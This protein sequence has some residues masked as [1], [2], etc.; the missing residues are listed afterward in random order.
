MLKFYKA[1]LFDLDG[2]LLDTL[3]DLG[4]S[5]N[6]VLSEKG[7]PTHPLDSYRYFAGDGSAMLIT[8][9]LPEDKRNDDM[10]RRCLDAFLKDYRRNWNVSTKPY[11]GIAEML[12]SLT[13]HPIKL[14]VL[15]N[16]PHDFAKLC[17]N[18]LLNKWRFEAILGQ[19]KNVPHK[20]DPAGA[21]EAAQILNISP[22]DFLF[23]GD[24]AVDMKTAL[25]A[26]MYPVGALWGFRPAKELLDSGAR[27]LIN[28][29]P[30]ILNLLSSK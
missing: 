4:N 20:P 13:A 26:G 1:I 6:R 30:E 29:P 27:T 18:E 12:D 21:L 9:A 2:T 10:V 5:A 23:L 3:E 15:S 28:E 22:L 19:R 11:E 14:A 25:A 16:K 24:S 17:V 8:R 7:F